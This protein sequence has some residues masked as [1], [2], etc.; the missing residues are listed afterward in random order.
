VT[1]SPD[2]APL[3]QPVRRSPTYLRVVVTTRCNLQCAYC[4]MEGDP[5]QSGTP[6]GLDAELLGRCL[7]V[8]AAAGMRKIKLL[9]GEPLLR[10]DLPELV[11]RLRQAAPEADLSI[12]T[13][14]VVP[15]EALDAVL[16]AGL[17][18]VNVS[19]HGF[20]PAAMAIRYPNALRGWGRRQAFLE[21]VMAWGRPL[22]LNYVLS[23]PQDEA[24]LEA[25]L[26]WA[27][28]L[29]LVVNVLDNLSTALG[30]R[31]VLRTLVR[32]RGEP[33]ER[34]RV[35]DPDSLTTMHL[36][37]SDGLTVE[38]K[39]EELGR[40]GAFVACAGCPVRAQCKEG[41]Y[42]LRL[43]HRGNLQACMDR[44]DLAIPLADLVSDGGVGAGLEAWRE[45]MGRLQG[46]EASAQVRGWGRAPEELR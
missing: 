9:G 16:G 17:D 4:H 15:T 37:W 43:T 44:P 34:T 14:G 5:H 1:I 27:A 29:P 6:H 36:R 28:P 13:A 40:L 24:D 22:K 11:A 10:R 41:I 12:I 3:I 7:E 26:D 31:G 42:A 21:R 45:F 35:E 19:I 23:G 33:S 39:H 18:R 25:L 20:L 38:L 46:D 32:L 2:H 8:A 30:W